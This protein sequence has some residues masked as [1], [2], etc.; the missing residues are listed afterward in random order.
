M[1]LDNFR[2]RT[3]IWDTVNKDF[4][5]PIQIMQGDVNARTL[6]IKIVDNG[7]ELDLTGHLLK[8]TYQYTNNSNSGFV[9]ISPKDLTKGEFILVIPTEMT[10]TGVIEANLILLNES[11]EQVIVSKLLTFI[12]DNST[13]TDLAQEVNNKIDDFTKLLLEN[14]PQ[15]M[16]SELN[17]L[18]A[19]TDSNM[20]NIELKANK[21]DLDNLKTAIT[22]QGVEITTARGTAPTLNVRLNKMD[23]KD[24]ETTA[25]LADIVTNVKLYGAKGDEVTDDTLAIQNAI[26]SLTNGGTIYFPNGTYISR[27]LTIPS[28]ITIKGASKEKTILKLKANAGTQ[29]LKNADATNGNTGITIEDIQFDG[30]LANNAADKDVLVFDKCKNI[31]IKNI[32]AHSSM[33]AP[34]LLNKG[35]FYTVKDSEFYNGKYG[36][37][38]FWVNDSTFENCVFRNSR[39]YEADT[40]NGN[41]ASLLSGRDGH[42]F[43]GGHRNTVSNCI[44]FGNAVQGF[45]S[46]SETD[47]VTVDRCTDIVYVNCI[48]YNNGASGFNVAGANDIHYS[49]CIAYGNGGVTEQDGYHG[50]NLYGS[51]ETDLF[52]ITVNGGSFHNNNKSGIAAIHG[53]RSLS[54]INAKIHD[55]GYDGINMGSPDD[56]GY[57]LKDI[58]IIDVDSYANGTHGMYLKGIVGLH[59]INNS[60]FNNDKLQA[61]FKTGILITGTSTDLTTDAIIRGNRCYDDS[62]RATKQRVGMEIDYT[63]YSVIEG[64]NL[65]GNAVSTLNWG[66]NNG[67]NSKRSKN[68]GH[69]T[70]NGG[71]IAFNGTGSLTYFSIAHGLVS[72]PTKFSVTPNSTDAKGESYVTVD[73]TNIHVSFSNAPVSGANNVKFVWTAEV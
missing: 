12:S 38:A 22:S 24:A 33:G 48:S 72:T 57:K 67:S 39:P 73:A 29:L 51:G 14:M 26:N 11:L 56:S 66:A 32:V 31:T 25:Q 17:D 5:Q 34:L 52:N 61:G 44:S 60:S 7:V 50:L 62:A 65:R 53:G 36:V 10:T 47:G 3:I 46:H 21:T 16:R 70:E 59:L 49:N 42:Q 9:M 2:N 8:L 30:N 4:P 27:L 58:K 23:D 37:Y 68:I 64:N 1:S 13:V 43:K 71:L 6:L 40:L 63:D 15:V 69:V 28:N 45:D 54:I 20:S 19:Q 41:R 18:H 55:N 35:S